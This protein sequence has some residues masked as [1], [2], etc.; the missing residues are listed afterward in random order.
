MMPRRFPFSRSGTQ[1]TEVSLSFITERELA[2]SSSFIASETMTGFF[3]WM[4][5]A[6]MESES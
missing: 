1:I 3:S 5:L 2:N 4:T 6:T